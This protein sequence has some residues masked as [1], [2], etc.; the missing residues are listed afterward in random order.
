MRINAIVAFLTVLLIV[1]YLFVMQIHP[2]EYD[3]DMG[4][5][6][7]DSALVYFEQR[8]GTA[9]LERFLNSRLG[10]KIASIDFLAVGKEVGVTGDVLTKFEKFLRIFDRTK[11]DQLVHEILGKR[12]SLALLTPIDQITPFNFSEYLKANIIVIAEPKHKAELLEFLGENYSKYQ[13]D[14]SVSIAQYGNHHIKRI[15]TQG[16]RISLVTIDG[17]FI[18][19]FNERQLRRCIDAFDSK[20]SLLSN[21]EEFFALK[22][23]FNNPNRFLYLPVKNVRDFTTTVL[24]EYNFPRKEILLKELTTTTGF[25][26]FGYGAWRG[27]I[28]IE[29][30]IAVRYDPAKVNSLVK[31]HLSIQPSNSSMFSL[32]PDN[33]ILYYWSNTFNFE[34]FL[35]Y[36]EDSAL[37]GGR[38]DLFSS[39][40]EMITGK[41]PEETLSL[42]G[43]EV[44][45][46]LAQSTEKR[47]FSIP[48]G[49]VF[50]EVKE[51]EEL[52]KVLGN[53]IAEYEITMKEKHYGST[54]YFY[55]TRSFQDGVRPLYGFHDNF[56]FFGN[57]SKL[58]ENV[59][60]NHLNGQSLLNKTEIRKID[61][62]LKLANNSITYLNNVELI[63]VT[64][65]LVDIL[66]TAI[67]IKDREA[68]VKMRVVID[69]ILIPLL[70]GATMYDS[71]VTRSYFMPNTVII[72]SKTHLSN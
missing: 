47:Q 38:T 4:R 28:G 50:V 63:E 51:V 23:N 69:R 41:S 55:W 40:F 52:K 54:T 27:H 13:D 17:F 45:L 16:E 9:E 29:D 72:K 20:S 53:I 66:G 32:V 44:S 56:L 8:E 24:G 46:V 31:K 3:G 14:V 36:L 12:L 11:D 42:L 58:L 21:N 2:D 62:G 59:L 1:T 30:K 70:D 6:V 15:N 35:L 19:C 7:P 18:M 33:P 64:K 71:S 34:H 39:N 25:S 65:D 61:P 60:D 26:S 43:D 48:L 5:F 37:P 49:M 10:A 67:A 57:S 68:A 22:N